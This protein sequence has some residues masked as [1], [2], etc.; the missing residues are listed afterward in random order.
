MAPCTPSEQCFCQMA[1]CL[2]L[3]SNTH[4]EAK[5]VLGLVKD[6]QLIISHQNDTFLT[7]VAN[8]LV[9]S[10]SPKSVL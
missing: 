8:R 5:V 1:S 7:A 10:G 6:R 4:E 3:P 9:S 2:L